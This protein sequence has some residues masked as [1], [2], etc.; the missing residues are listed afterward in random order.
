MDRQRLKDIMLDQK[1]VFNQKRDLIDRDIEVTKY[2]ESAQVV[3]ISGIRR[4]GKSS[5]LFLIKEQMGLAETA[6]CYFNFDDERITPEIS[7]LENIVTL[8][9]EIYGSYPTLFFD[10]IQNVEGWEKFVNRMYERGTK[11]FVTGSNAR[12]LSS[13]IATSLTGRN[14]VIELFPFSFAEYLRFLRADYNLNMLTPG[15][16]ALLQKDLNHYMEIGGFPLVVRENDLELINS[17]YQDILYRDIVS[18]YRLSQVNELKEL[19]LYLA[20]NVGKIFSYAMLQKVTGI[21]SLSTIKDYLEYFRQSY[22]FYYLPKFDYSVK[23]QIMNSKKVYAIDPGFVNRLGFRFSENRGRLLE[24]VVFNELLRRGNE[25]YYHT[26]KYECDFVLKAGT[27]VVGLIQVT[28]RLNHENV[29]RE[30]NGLKEAMQLYNLAGGL[31]LVN[32]PVDSSLETDKSV[33]IQNVG[34]WL[35]NNV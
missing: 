15:N 19:G 22:L 14:K 10:E 12:L 17:Y 7:I 32:E 11:V 5:L 25:V 8:H 3:V 9:I 4:C 27:E 1:E 16:R 29:V 31:L 6:Y 35:L 24:N 18:R 2:I 21:K 20:S 13:E 30:I 26:G 23:K 33:T 28:D 34:Q